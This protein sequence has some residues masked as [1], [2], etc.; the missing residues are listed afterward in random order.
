MFNCKCV[1]CGR[2]DSFLTRE[3]A[4]HY[5]WNVYVENE[6]ICPICVIKI[7]R[8]IDSCLAKNS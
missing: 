1:E 2:E 8:E 7:L 3:L 5:Q 4:L 6:D